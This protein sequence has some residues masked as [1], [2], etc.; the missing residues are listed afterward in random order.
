MPTLE[1]FKKL[2]WFKERPQIIK[3]LISQFPYA[4]TVRINETEQIAYILSWFED[5]SMRVVITEKDNPHVINSMCGTYTVFGYKPEDLEFLH[6]NPNLVL[7]FE[8]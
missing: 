7:G 4:A 2:P 3:D 6:E 5:G 8:T 1:E